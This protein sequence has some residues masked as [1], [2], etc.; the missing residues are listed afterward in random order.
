MFNLQPD[1]RV[2]VS[3]F[4]QRRFESYDVQLS[5]D[6]TEDSISGGALTHGEGKL[7]L[8]FDMNGDLIK[9]V[10]TDRTQ[11]TAFMIN[12]VM[13]E[14][15]VTFEAGCEPSYCVLNGEHA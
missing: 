6:L 3:Q 9:M 8:R 7:L 4:S 1:R 11:D 12:T 14:F 15:E 13:R 10:P 5:L 2:N